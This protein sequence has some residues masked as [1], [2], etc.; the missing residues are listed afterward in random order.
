MTLNTKSEVQLEDSFRK[1]QSIIQGHNILKPNMLSPL[2]IADFKLSKS[3]KSIQSF[4]LAMGTHLA[5]KKMT[6]QSNPMNTAFTNV[7]VFL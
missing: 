6:Q 4:I 2:N 7:V 5:D 1:L 3:F